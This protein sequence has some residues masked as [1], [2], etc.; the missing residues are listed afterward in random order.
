MN[1]IHAIYRQLY[2]AYGELHWWPAETPF[3]VMVGAILT[4]NTNWKNV[5]KA[6]I[7]LKGN[8][9]PE[10][11]RHM[12]KEG[13]KEAI[14]PS[15]F[16]NQK[17]ERLLSLTQWLETYE[18]NLER[19]DAKPTQDIRAE[20]LAIHGI[21]RETAD[22]ILVYV[23]KRCSFV[24]DA[25]TRRLFD[26][27]GFQVPKDY[28]AFRE[29]IEEAL[30]HD[31]GIYNRYHGLIVECCKVHCRKKPQCDTCPLKDGC[32]YAKDNTSSKED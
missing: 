29:Q 6:L 12:D 31:N 5:E 25:Y 9:S 1:S 30:P 24:V 15:G 19:I 10:A 17:A 3:E 7:G 14:R 32:D 22:C 23:F 27:L 16:Y 4:Q 20:L 8:L 18:D 26:R 2:E 13:L 21:G 28:D 11:L